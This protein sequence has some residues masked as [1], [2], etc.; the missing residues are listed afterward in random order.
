MLPEHR[1]AVLL[2]QVKHR[3]IDSCKWHT[4]PR[5]PSLYSDHTCDSSHFPNQVLT[6]LAQPNE[7][8]QISFS[9]DGKRLASC[10][11]DESIYIWDMTTLTLAMKLDGRHKQGVGNISWSPDDT[12]LVSCGRDNCA[13]LWD[14]S[15]RQPS[16]VLLASSFKGLTDFSTDWQFNTTHRCIPGTCQQLCLGP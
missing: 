7:V 3:Q 14:L 5:S 9:H 15:V 11:A 8:W 10:G 13:R 1:L 6:E 16:P 4:D 2:Q 12:M